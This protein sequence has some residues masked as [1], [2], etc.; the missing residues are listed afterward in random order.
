MPPTPST[1]T[2]AKASSSNI[3]SRGP[4]SLF[5]G[6][7]GGGD[8]LSLGKFI[9]HSV[10]SQDILRV[11][12][13]GLD[14]APQVLDMGVNRALVAIIA[15]IIDLVHQLRAGELAARLAPQHG[16]LI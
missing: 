15:H 8:L 16:Q 1:I 11:A 5:R 6:A 12:R 3:N 2:S 10:D 7:S 13:I 9:P 14:L 4:R